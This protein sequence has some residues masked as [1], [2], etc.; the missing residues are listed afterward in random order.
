MRSRILGFAALICVGVSANAAE[1]SIVYV[2][3]TGTVIRG[4]DPGIIFGQ[5]ANLNGLSY[6]VRYVFDTGSYSDSQPTENFVFG[7]EAF[8]T[9]SPLV[10][11]AVLT[12]GGVSI[13]IGGNSV[14]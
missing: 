10:G 1:A 4:I 8:G 2:T 12:I 6:Q 7:G 9:P 13:A 11:S 5:G 3:Y 14:A